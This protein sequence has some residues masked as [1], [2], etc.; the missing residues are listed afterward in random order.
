[1]CSVSVLEGDLSEIQDRR[2]VVVKVYATSAGRIT[3][4]QYKYFDIYG[5][6]AAYE[7]K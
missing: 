1:M 5:K 6:E 3:F 4:K 2:I 7:Q